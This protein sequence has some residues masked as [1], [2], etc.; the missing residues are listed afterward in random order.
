MPELS[1][2]EIDLNNLLLR[3]ALNNCLLGSIKRR[4]DKE[5]VGEVQVSHNACK[6]SSQPPK[7]QRGIVMSNDLKTKPFNRSSCKS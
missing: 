6:G 5:Q 1:S 2:T 4:Y 7:P 3:F